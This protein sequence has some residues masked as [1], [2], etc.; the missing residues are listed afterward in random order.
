MKILYIA[1]IR[2]PTEKAH[3]VQIMKMCEAFADLGHK[4]ELVLPWRFNPIKE[5]IFEYYNVRKNFKIKKILSFDLIWLGKVGFWIQS[6]TFAKLAAWYAFFKKTDAI[7]SR[8]ELPIF[9]LSFFKKNIFWETHTGQ[10]NFFVK[11]LLKRRVGIVA[12]TE[13]LRNFYIKKGVDSEKIIVAPDGIDLT[14]FLNKFDKV[15]VRKE[16]GLPLDKKIALYIGRLDGWKGAETLLAASKLLPQNIQVVLI[17]G[18]PQEVFRLKK[19]YQQAIFLGFLPYRELAKN[20]TAADVLILPNSGKNEVSANFTSPLKLF[21]YMASGL[22]IVASDLLSIKEI[23]NND[24]AFFFE[25]DNPKSLA[26]AINMVLRDNE[27]SDK[28]SKQASL[29]V[30]KYT[31]VKRA[32]KITDFIKSIE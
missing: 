28:I 23:L 21:S 19:E 8:D 1:N 12:I 17:G 22:P 7:Y 29:D 18:E 31:W 9:Y 26:E 32:E 16:L 24:N 13:G 10:Y 30:E 14:D 2:L 20:Q 5:N 15:S 25:S 3:G 27:L 6:L 4:V 11:Q